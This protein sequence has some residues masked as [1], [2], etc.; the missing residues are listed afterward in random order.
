MK[1]LSTDIP[2]QVTSYTETTSE[3][4]LELAPASKQQINVQDEVKDFWEPPHTEPGVP[5]L[6]TMPGVQSPND[7][8]S[9]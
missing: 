4:T 1:A 2:K 3:I 6:L 8:V 9:Y 5:P 7:L